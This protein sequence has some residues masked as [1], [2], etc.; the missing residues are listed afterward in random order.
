MAR[1]VSLGIIA[2]LIVCLGTTFY[3]VLAPFLMPLF[4]AA[5]TALFSQPLLHRLEKR[6][7]GRRKLAALTTTG[8]IFAVV[9]LPLLLGVFMGVHQFL[10]LASLGRDKLN[11][12]KAEVQ[13]SPSDTSLTETFRVLGNNIFDT[14]NDDVLGTE[15]TLFDAEFLDLTKA[16]ASDP[17]TLR[18]R[19]L[20][21]FQHQL[22]ASRGQMVSAMLELARK[23]VGVVGSTLGL[24]L[25][26]TAGQ[27]LGL[28]GMLAAAAVTLAVF[29]MALFYFLAEGPELIAAAQTLI[30][31][32]RAHQTELMTQFENSVRAVVLSTFLAA[33][34]QG[35]ATALV[36]KLLGFNHFFILL[37][38]ATFSAMIPMA[39][40]WLVWLPGV[41]WLWFEQSYGTAIFLGLFGIIVI[42]MMDNVIR[43]WVLQ[44]DTKLHPLLAFVSVLGGLQ[45]MGLWGVFVGPIVA[46]CLHSLI[47]IFNQELQADSDAASAAA[48]LDAPQPEPQTPVAEVPASEQSTL[49][50][51]SQINADLLEQAKAKSGP[52]QPT[53]EASA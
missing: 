14:V 17:E 18:A 19:R 44:S 5:M 15:P 10:D 20:E 33:F 1:F 38:V 40:T 12:V 6:F 45:V 11:D 43:T 25:G 31:V 29:S 48:K 37:I 35:L 46:C 39:G 23:T 7:K 24:V 36:M 8:C 50:E 9:M 47:E 28:L 30:P 42:G 3:Q 49:V 22:E 51:T 26:G 53:D 16:E 34:A 4:L 27:A 2:V 41:I 21:W 52:D 32:D 13:R